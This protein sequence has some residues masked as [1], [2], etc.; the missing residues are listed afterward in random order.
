[1]E[2][3]GLLSDAPFLIVAKNTIPA[4]NL[5]DCIAWLRANPDKASQGTTGVGGAG[6][7][8][9]V[10]FQHA[11]GTRYQFVPYRGAAQ[12]MQDLVAGNIDMEFDG[13]GTALPQVRAGRIKA[14]AVTAKSRL[15]I[16]SEIPTVDEAGLPGL[17]VSSWHGLRAPKGAPNNIVA[18]LNAAT[19]EASADPTVRR[20]LAEIGQEIFPREHQTPEVLGAFQKAEIDKWWPIIKAANIK[21]E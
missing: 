19:M 7:I 17:Y 11:T 16:A 2:P 3:I 12:A 9:G 1:L 6:D 14:F 15:G 5:V 10:L 13:P 20:R 21:G 8:A 4:T 18:R